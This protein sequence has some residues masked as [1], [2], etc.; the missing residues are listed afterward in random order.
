MDKV[1]PRY[2]KPVTGMDDPVVHTEHWDLAK[3]AFDE[4]K[5]KQA[6]LEVIRFVNSK[7]LEGVDTSGEVDITGYQGSA[8]MN[9]HVDDDVF[10]V[11]APFLKITDGT[12]KVAL[13]RKIAEINFSAMSL[14][15]IV[16]H[17]RRLCF[18]YEMPVALAQPN[19]VYDILWEVSVNADKYDDLLINHF[20]ADFVMAPSKKE[21]TPEES[22]EVRWQIEQLFEDFR[23]IMDYFVRHRHEDYKWEL[24]AIT[25][26]KFS[27]MPYVH[28]QLRT[29][30]INE[31]SQM[32]DSDISF[33]YRAD[34]A[35]RYVKKLMET[36]MEEL[37]ENIY[38]APQFVSLRWRMTE[39]IIAERLKNYVQTVET[40][41]QK[42]RLM[43]QYYYLKIIFHKLIY[44]YNLEKD[45]L[46]AIQHTLVAVNGKDYE[47]AV[48]LLEE[49][50]YKMLNKKLKPQAKPKSKGGFFSRLFNG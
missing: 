20:G 35:A 43:Y 14:A 49:L 8:Q 41:H 4:K 5:Y 11:K 40:N 7:A 21:L 29:D 23:Q 10:R 12:N 45:Y 25:L 19:K 30:L 1:F 3:E 22:R 15:Q 47:E 50:F 17:D 26:L 34:R 13:L 33:D 38:H 2:Y 39:D 46:E 27:N 48:P 44:D 16:R 37:F 31:I 36:P 32:F 9:I 28:G 18:E 6:V 42:E 24:S